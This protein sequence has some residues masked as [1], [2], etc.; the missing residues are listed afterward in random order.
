[1][2]AEVLVQLDPESTAPRM[3]AERVTVPLGSRS[4]RDPLE[5]VVLGPR[6]D[7]PMFDALRRE[8]LG[9]VL[10]GIS[11]LGDNSTGV[12]SLHPDVIAALMA[13]LNH[14]MLR[15]LTWRGFPTDTRATFFRQFFDVSD[16]ITSET[17]ELEREALYD[18]EAMFM[19]GLS[20]SLASGV[21]PKAG[22]NSVV[23]VVRGELLRRYPDTLVYAVPGEVDTS[24]GVATRSPAYFT[25]TSGSPAQFTGVFP[26]FRAVIDPDIMLLG[27]ELTQAELRGDMDAPTADA[28]YYFVLQEPLTNTRFGL[29]EGD[30]RSSIESWSELTWETM[31]LAGGTYV[32]ASTSLPAG[33]AFEPPDDAGVSWGMGASHMAAILHQRPF[34]IAIHADDMLGESS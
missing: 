3:A 27:F 34:L 7:A 19:W 28:G 5:P 18:I 32:H 10:P 24:G 9:F 29:D 20:E 8:D 2:V 22:S 21:R 11:E 25:N 23:L 17:T 16:Q 26:S 6:F 12:L 4:A 15:E 13:G 14:E 1:L 30:A 33:P 31:T